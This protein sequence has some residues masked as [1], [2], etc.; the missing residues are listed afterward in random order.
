MEKNLTEEIK[1]G[2]IVGEEEQPLK[3]LKETGSEIS[4]KVDEKVDEVKGG[5]QEIGSSL[6]G[7]DSLD[8][9]K[10]RGESG[11]V[12]DEA[13]ESGDEAKEGVDG[14]VGSESDRKIEKW[15]KKN[16]DDKKEDIEKYRR[17]LEEENLL[18]GEE[19]IEDR[20][21]ELRGEIEEFAARRAEAA[22]KVRE[23]LSGV[24]TPKLEGI[25]QEEAK[26]MIRELAE[27]ARNDLDIAKLDYLLIPEAD[28]MDTHK[29]KEIT[30][31]NLQEMADDLEGLENFLIEFEA[32]SEADKKRA[33]EEIIAF[34]EKIEKFYNKHPEIFYILA[35]AGVIVGLK[36]L[37]IAAGIAVSAWP[38]WL[39]KEVLVAST[40]GAGMIAGGAYHFIKKE[41]RER[42]GKLIGGGAGALAGVGILG[43]SWLLDKEKWDKFVKG[44]SKEGY[45]D[46]Y[47]ASVTFFGL[48]ENETSKS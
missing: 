42:L 46:W 48:E 19:S 17:G 34:A 23:S 4:G 43:L 16:P 8:A 20:I 45:P 28:L 21:E 40:V 33:Q 31:E 38:V 36:L 6:H 5:D 9:D 10:I 24:D 41:N 44:I 22:M 2:E 18:A 30:I 29:D 14:I 11:R 7:D 35:A 1:R 12:V 37:F 13:V 26:E 27:S 25:E 32:M 47:K 39:T 3:N 15:N